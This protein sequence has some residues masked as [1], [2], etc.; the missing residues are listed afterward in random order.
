MSSKYKIAFTNILDIDE[1]LTS[2]CHANG[3]CTN[4]EPSYSCKCQSGFIGDGF[5]CAGKA[6]FF[7][8][9]HSEKQLQDF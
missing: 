8:D 6:N 4:T 1:C 7:M 9:L 5:N 2:P 3:I